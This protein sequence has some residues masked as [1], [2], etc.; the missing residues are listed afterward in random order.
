MKTIIFL[1]PPG[2]GKGT[3][4]QL[5]KERD[6]FIQ[7]STGDLLREAVKNQT[8]LGMKAKQFM[9][10]GKLVPDDL[11]IDLISEKLEE[12]KDKNIIFD[13]FPRTVPQAEALKDLLNKKN[14][15]V[16]AVILFD[17]EE[18][19]VI[20]RLSGRR[21]CPKCGSVYHI[22]FNPPKNDNLCDKCDTP[23]IQRDDDKEEV[24]RKRLE[25]Y[26]SQTA[27]LIEYYKDVLLKIDATRPPEEV[28]KNIKNVL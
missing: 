1:G 23:L 2:A 21:V 12:F 3:Q 5:L 8:P 6:N 7:I 19:E 27:P 26:H 28:Y 4:S 25:V 10:E 22:I 24:I 14:R 20:K 13:G 15:K 9:D 16:D 11:I 17:I 18:E